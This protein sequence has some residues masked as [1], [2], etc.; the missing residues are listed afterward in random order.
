MGAGT[1]AAPIKASPPPQ[2]P[3]IKLKDPYWVGKHVTGKYA[4]QK[5][6]RVSDSGDKYVILRLISD[7]KNL[8]LKFGCQGTMFLGW[9]TGND[10]PVTLEQVGDK[11][12]LRFCRGQPAET[13]E[14]FTIECPF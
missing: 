10:C 9:D 2:P 5:E 12:R 7:A 1:V 14:L 3:T 13:I 8:T 6:I 4:V 11:A